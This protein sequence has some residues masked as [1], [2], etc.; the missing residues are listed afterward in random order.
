MAKKG[1]KRAEPKF[2]KNDVKR[3]SGDTRKGKTQQKKGN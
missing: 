2:D 3:G 1:M